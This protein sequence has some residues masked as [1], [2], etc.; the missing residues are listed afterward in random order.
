MGTQVL[1]FSVKLTIESFKMAL[2]QGALKK[3]SVY[4]IYTC[5]HGKLTKSNEFEN[6]IGKGKK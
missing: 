1:C 4:T 6:V 3:S 5:Y 2:G